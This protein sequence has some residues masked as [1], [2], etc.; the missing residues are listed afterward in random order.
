M[1]SFSGTVRVLKTFAL[2]YGLWRVLAVVGIRDRQLA[3]EKA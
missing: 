3:E 2:H 1:L